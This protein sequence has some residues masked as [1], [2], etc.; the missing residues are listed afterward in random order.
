LERGATRREVKKKEVAPP[1]ARGA[2]RSG[3]DGGFTQTHTH[4][5]QTRTHTHH[6]QRHTHPSTLHPPPMF[7]ADALTTTAPQRA[8][9]VAVLRRPAVAAAASRVSAAASADADAAA[10][11]RAA[12]EGGGGAKPARMPPWAPASPARLSPPTP[13]LLLRRWP[14]VPLRPAALPVR[15][16]GSMRRLLPPL[17]SQ[18]LTARKAKRAEPERFYM[19]RR[20]V[21]RV[22][23]NSFS[24]RG[25]GSAPA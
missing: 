24:A 14:P 8:A 20:C 6:K 1:A 2:L 4:T 25:S 12:A 15:R 13:P 10:A 23:K 19:G 3:E 7:T 21:A 11:A 18:T 9:R 5:P 16:A 22:E 17:P